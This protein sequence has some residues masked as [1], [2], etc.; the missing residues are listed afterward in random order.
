[1][2]AKPADLQVPA[3]QGPLSALSRPQLRLLD[4]GLASV[5]SMSEAE[6]GK[7]ASAATLNAGQAAVDAV[8]ALWGRP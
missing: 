6:P 1:M 7:R 8:N 2:K 4:R 5:D 3:P